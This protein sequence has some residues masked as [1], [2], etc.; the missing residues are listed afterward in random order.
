[1]D[2]ESKQVWVIDTEKDWVE[3]VGATLEGPQ[4]RVVKA[5][6]LD[7]AL[8]TLTAT[9][10][11][12][13]NSVALV[14]FDTLSAAPA[15]TVA[16]LNSCMPVV[17]LYAVDPSLEKL[18]AVFQQGAFD[19]LGKPYDEDQLVA[20][21]EQAFAA[22]RIVASR[23][24]LLVTYAGAVLVIDDDPAWLQVLVGELPTMTRVDTAASRSEAEEKLQRQNYDLVV[25]DLRLAKTDELNYEGLVL[26]DLVRAL[27]HAR[28]RFTQI[29]VSSGYATSVHVRESY[30]KY[31]V[32]YYVDKH[33]F[34][35]ARY[36]DAIRNA[37]S[38]PDLAAQ[39]S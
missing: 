17:V 28:R 5:S 37:L 2:T 27:D 4:Y 36:R 25:C 26:M 8:A 19:C 30:L 1:M 15:S 3:F 23:R 32:C 11:P 38:D 33:Q 35:P 14:D 22:A 10:L 9:D 20:L 34:S 16:E 18:G 13:Q 12:L 31:R 7:G 29:I 21:V 6:S 24:D 39:H